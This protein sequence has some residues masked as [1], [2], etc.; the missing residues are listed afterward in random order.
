MTERDFCFWLQGFVELN[1]SE[2]TSEQ[3]QAIKDHL[4]T[5]FVKVTPEVKVGVDIK[6]PTGDL[7]K[8]AEAIRESA[9][10]YGGEWPFRRAHEPYYLGSPVITC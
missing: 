9:K 1:G 10:R 7:D 6:A 8:I 3:W 2:P 4:K 5:V